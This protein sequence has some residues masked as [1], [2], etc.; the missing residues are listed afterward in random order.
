MSTIKLSTRRL[1]AW[2]TIVTLLVSASACGDALLTGPDAR[3][4]AEP[5]FQTASGFAARTVAGGPFNLRAGPGTNYAVVGTIGGNTSVTIVCQAYGTTVNGTWGS[6]NIWDQLSTG[7]WITDGYVYTGRNGLV[8]PLCGSTGG[9]NTGGVGID[10]CPA[11]WT[12]RMSGRGVL[13]CSRDVWRS[14]GTLKTEYVQ[15]LDLRRG[16]RVLSLIDGPVASTQD[17]S[18]AFRRYSVRDWWNQRNQLL[19]RFCMV[20]GA[21]FEYPLDPKRFSFPV[22]N[23]GYLHS[24]GNKAD[25]TW[26]RMLILDGSRAYIQSYD[27]TSKDYTKVRDALSRYQTVIVGRHP[28]LPDPNAQDARTYVGIRDL[29][30]NA[31]GEILYFYTSMEASTGWVNDVLSRIFSATQT[32]MLD[33]GGST[34][35]VCQNTSLTTNG[36]EVPHV[37]LSFEATQ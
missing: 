8:A 5:R 18:P 19:N 21:F 14:N 3:T 31:S 10:S 30:G 20:N 11:W 17:P 4:P 26:K 33:G 37:F 29:D 2:L 12:T 32:M 35:L 28:E 22:K 7:A 36:R 25:G 16:A 27:L 9:G 1:L 13:L 24:T 6:T 34:Q 23:A 15:I